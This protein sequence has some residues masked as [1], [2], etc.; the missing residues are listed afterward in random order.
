MNSGTS[1][2]TKP[3]SW[4]RHLV[5]T[6]FRGSDPSI[7]PFLRSSWSTPTVTWS[8][9]DRPPIPLLGDLSITKFSWDFL[10]TGLILHFEVLSEP[11]RHDSPHLLQM[12]H[13]YFLQLLPIWWGSSSLN[14]LAALLWTRFT[15]LKVWR[16]RM[17]HD[18]PVWYDH[19]TMTFPVLTLGYWSCITLLTHGA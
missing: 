17:E 16:H 9:Q 7:A 15:P 1:W 2:L 4:A 11:F 3:Q 14:S 5:Q 10:F 13:P 18:S 6:S 12:K 19:R 8:S